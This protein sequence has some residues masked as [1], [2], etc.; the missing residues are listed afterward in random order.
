MAFINEKSV[1][2]K[3][4]KG[5]NIILACGVIEFIKPC[6]QG[7]FRFFHLLD[8]VTFPVVRFCHC[9][10]RFDFVY[11][12]FYDRRLTLMRQRDFFKLRMPD[13]DRIIV[14]CCDT[15]TEFFA[16]CRLKILFCGG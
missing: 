13:N 5:H 14:P 8:C 11:L 15:G 7:F 2:A 4:F 6:R 3:L 1:H 16:V 12:T 9:N 10:R